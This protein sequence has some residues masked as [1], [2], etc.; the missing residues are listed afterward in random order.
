M[1]VWGYLALA[2][3]LFLVVGQG[4]PV[5]GVRQIVDEFVYQRGARLT[6]AVYG[7]DGVV[8][9]DPQSLADQVGVDVETY[10]HARCLSSEEGNS[11]QAIKIAVAWAMWNEAA[12][13]GQDISA[14]ML[15]AKN[16]AH[17][18]FFGTQKDIDPASPNKGKSDR[19]AS[20]ALDPYQGDV[21]ICVAIQAGTLPDPTG[22]A[23][24]FDRPAGESDPAHIAENRITA[25][26]T[27]VD[28]PGI[29]SSVIRFWRT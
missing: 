5:D 19:Y 11:D 20:T 18:G 29:D 8:R 12:R 17:S 1:D 7:A 9:V 6:H 24:Q 15:H 2:F 25:G 14:L 3:V 23:Q 28:V 4:D 27:Q 13:R 16:P 26:A 10:A 21:D 22:G